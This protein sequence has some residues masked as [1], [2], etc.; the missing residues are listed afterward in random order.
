MIRGSSPSPRE[1][2]PRRPGRRRRL[3]SALPRRPRAAAGGS[4]SPPL[5]LPPPSSSASLAAARG[6]GQ[7]KPG[8]CRRRR[9]PFVLALGGNRRGD[10]LPGLGAARRR[11]LRRGYELG[12]VAGARRR[13]WGRGGGPVPGGVVWRGPLCGLWW[14]DGRRGGGCARGAGGVGTP[15]RRG[16]GQLGPRSSVSATVGGDGA[17]VVV[18]C[19]SGCGGRRGRSGGG[20]GWWEVGGALPAT[21]RIWARRAQICRRCW[22]CYGSVLG[23]GLGSAGGAALATD[24]IWAR[25]VRIC[26]RWRICN[27]Q[28]RLATE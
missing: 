15:G 6:R 16:C 21:D 4:S 20:L 24:R 28:A 19:S 9:G 11:V 13:P 1:A 18:E 8:R 26:R 12:G 5:P 7:A 3:I 17:E 25:R 27:L 23:H 14:R 2:N 10:L 22:A